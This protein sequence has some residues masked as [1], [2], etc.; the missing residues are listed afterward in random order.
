MDEFVTDVST[1]DAMTEVYIDTLE[2]VKETKQLIP[3]AK[4][5]KFVI[6]KAESKASKDNAYRWLNLQLQL[7]DGIDEKAS[8]KNKV[9]FGKVC[10]F[11]DMTKY[12]GKDY[13]DKKQHLVEL[14]RLL[15]AVG[16]DLANVKINEQF[17]EELKGKMVMADILQTKPTEEY[18]SDNEVRY[19]KAVKAEDVI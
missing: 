14:K 16:V 7:V 2:D 3:A 9:V 12:A 15:S 19:F 18:D 8:Y 5:V 6:K 11:A 1:V 4:N 10:Y 17:L 13:F